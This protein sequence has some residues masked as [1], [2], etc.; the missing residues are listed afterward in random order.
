MKLRSTLLII[1]ALTSSLMLAADDDFSFVFYTDVHF[2]SD[3]VAQEGYQKAIDKIN[4]L[5]VDFVMDGGDFLFDMNH[6]SWEEISSD[7]E[8]YTDY[9]AKI[10]APLYNVMGNHDVLCTSNKCKSNGGDD[11]HYGKNLF[12]EM[13]QENTY[14]TFNHKGWQFFILDCIELNDSTMMSYQIDQE[15]LDWISQ[16]L[17]EMDAETPIVLVS[18]VPF[19]TASAMY[20]SGP[21][22]RNSSSKVIVNAAEVLKL[23][24]KYNLKLTLSGHL[25]QYENITIDK[26]Q[27]VV[28][29]AVCGFWWR[30]PFG[31][32]A[33]GFTKVDIVDGEAIVNYLNY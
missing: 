9:R 6:K 17:D 5:D 19:M 31:N 3:K 30:G 29:G 4:T 12:Q 28:S 14:S 11:T 2:Q 26:K 7:F 10:E 1:I 22:A 33:E 24:K 21:L 16:S 8:L 20:K 18:H 23:F 13:T 27:F 15:Q 32:T 25:H